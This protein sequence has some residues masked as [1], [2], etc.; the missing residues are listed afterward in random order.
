MKAGY[1]NTTPLNFICTNRAFRSI[2]VV[3]ALLGWVA[4]S[5]RCALW[6][7]L[8]SRQAAA[9]AQ[10]D[11][12]HKDSPQPGKTP[13]NEPRKA[14]CCMALNVLVPDGS[15]KLPD[16]PF[17]ESLTIPVEWISTAIQSL[18]VNNVILLDTGPPPD[19]PAFIELVLNRSL[20]S[21]APPF[22]A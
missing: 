20:H 18:A 4:L 3:A 13:D 15:T 6:Q 14:E 9:V 22:S 8:Q 11:C 10:H 16:S 21:H 7:L 2:F 5:Q 1:P 19:V 12:C 17:A